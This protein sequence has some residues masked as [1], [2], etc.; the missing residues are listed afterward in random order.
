MVK[1]QSTL[2]TLII[3]VTGAIT[4]INFA[5]ISSS[6]SAALF[7]ITQD[8][9]GNPYLVTKLLPLIL[10]CTSVPFVRTITGPLQ[11]LNSQPKGLLLT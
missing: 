4:F 8:P 3:L 6:M 1:T 10:G 7:G 9:S 2:L 5:K 11:T